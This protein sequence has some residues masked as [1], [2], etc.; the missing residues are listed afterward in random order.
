[1]NATGSTSNFTKV[2][3]LLEFLLVSY[4]LYV[5]MSS[6]YRSYQ[7]DRHI[8]QFEL[9]N[10]QLAVENEQLSKDFKYYTS[11][12]YKDKIAKQSLGLVNPGEEVIVLPAD[13]TVVVSLIEQ[14]QES[15]ERRWDSYTNAQ[16]WWIFFFD[17]DR[18]RR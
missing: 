5:L 18:F 6:V 4:M 10:T 9:E 16:K 15:N 12:E 11:P 7:I 17:R 1:M 3:L 14:E 13:E 2:V 8:E